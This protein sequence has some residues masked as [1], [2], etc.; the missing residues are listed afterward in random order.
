[1]APSRIAKIPPGGYKVFSWE[2][3]DQ[4]AHFDRDFALAV[5]I[6][7][8]SKILDD[9][10][11]P[12]NRGTAFSCCIAGAGEV[13]LSS[14]KV[15]LDEAIRIVTQKATSGSLAVFYTKA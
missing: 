6:A 12:S 8:A 10:V 13:R 14:S 1:M 2:A 11:P 3:S 5:E 7:T 9:E 15:S 4:G